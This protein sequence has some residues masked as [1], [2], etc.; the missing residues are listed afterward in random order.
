VRDT[1]AD[2]LD[3]NASAARAFLDGAGAPTR[4][5]R[6]VARALDALADVGLGYLAIGQAV[7]TLSGGERQRLVLAEALARTEAGRSLFLMDEPTTGL[8]AED[9]Q[10]LL[11]TFDRL[12]DAGHTVVV[13]EHHVDVVAAADWVIDLGPEGG[14]AGGRLV[15]AGTPES[16][17]ACEASWTGRALVSATSR[18]ACS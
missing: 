17:A 5:A 14:A 4:G 18:G 9:V 13:V 11:R 15:A 2:V 1:L 6:T 12:V 16:I 3:M 10:Q 8:H 7:R